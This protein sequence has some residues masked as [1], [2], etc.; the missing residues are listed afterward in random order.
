VSA[1]ENGL[2]KRF[3]LS[4]GTPMPVSQHLAQPARVTEESRGHSMLDEA[5]ELESFLLGPDSHQ[6]RH[7]LHNLPKT[8]FLGIEPHFAGLE[9]GIIENVVQQR[10]Q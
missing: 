5:G 1:W 8:E 3:C 10:E 7:L 4:G 6:I 2:N 9:F